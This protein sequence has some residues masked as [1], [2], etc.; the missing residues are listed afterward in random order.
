MRIEGSRLFGLQGV[1]IDNGNVLFHFGGTLIS[2]PDNALV[3]TTED[4]Y[5]TATLTGDLVERDI[6][7]ELLWKKTYNNLTSPPVYYH[8]KRNPNG[9]YTGTY[10]IVDGERKSGEVECQLNEYKGR[11]RLGM[12]TAIDSIYRLHLYGSREED[13]SPFYNG[14]LPK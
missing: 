5:G 7:E 10:Q 14:R 6:E 12:V 11:T 1:F 2:Y 3:G 13:R 8:L 4:H 9:L